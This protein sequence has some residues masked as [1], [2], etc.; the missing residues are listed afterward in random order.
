MVRA[1][2]E[3]EKGVAKYNEILLE[4]GEKNKFLMELMQIYEEVMSLPNLQYLNE[5]NTR[6]F[7]MENCKIKKPKF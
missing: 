2:A 3:Y 1:K 6:I 4:L 5:D 7:I